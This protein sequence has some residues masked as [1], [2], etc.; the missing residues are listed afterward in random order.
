MRVLVLCK[1]VQLFK[2]NSPFFSFRLNGV[3][4]LTKPRF[5]VVAMLFVTVRVFLLLFEFGGQ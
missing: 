3:V 5:E 2:K 1:R 4:W